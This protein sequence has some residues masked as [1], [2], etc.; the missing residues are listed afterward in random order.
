MDMLDRPVHARIAAF[1]ITPRAPQDGQFCLAWPLT[2][3]TH[4]QRKLF[5]HITP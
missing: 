3:F 5:R 1:Q 4:G 2:A